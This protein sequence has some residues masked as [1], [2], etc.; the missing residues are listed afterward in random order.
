MPSVASHDHAEA[1]SDMDTNDSQLFSSSNQQGDD[2]SPEQSSY[3]QLSPPNI[4]KWAC[5]KFL[6]HVSEEHHLTY[7]GVSKLSDSVQWLVDTLF[8]QLKEKFYSY[9]SESNLAS[10]DKDALFTMCEPDNIFSGLH[11]RYLREKFYMETF[12]YVV[13]KKCIA[14]VLQPQTS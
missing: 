4:E 9:F 2:W 5:A 8:S 10:V 7:E 3:M 1:E 14:T 6:L 11:S 12:N 13:M